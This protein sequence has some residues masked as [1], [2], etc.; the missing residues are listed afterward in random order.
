MNQDILRDRLSEVISKG[1]TAVSIAR[2]LG[3]T[4][5]DLG[6]FKNGQIN[7]IEYEARK[8]DKYLS[9]VNIPTDIK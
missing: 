6:R 9:M 3:I 2:V 4:A 1:L 7:L 8:L 5:N